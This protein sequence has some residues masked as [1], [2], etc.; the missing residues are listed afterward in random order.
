MTDKI[1]NSRDLDV[2][3]KGVEIIKDVCESY[4]V[5]RKKKGERDQSS[6]KNQAMRYEIRATRYQVKC[7]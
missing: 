2:C 1:R 7:V 3:K 5:S 4:L 6:E